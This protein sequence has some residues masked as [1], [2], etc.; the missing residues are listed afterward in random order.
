MASR[1]RLARALAATGLGRDSGRKLLT[2]LQV[3]FVST[4]VWREAEELDISYVRSKGTSVVWMALSRY[5]LQETIADKTT[6][7]IRH[8]QVF[9]SATR[10]QSLTNG[11]TK[12]HE[13]ATLKD[14]V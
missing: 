2:G 11:G 6:S 8:T 10:T 7:E 14:L 13:S 5:V 12:Q 4:E 3:P 1:S 9:A